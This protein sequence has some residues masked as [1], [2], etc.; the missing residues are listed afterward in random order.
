MDIGG[1]RRIQQWKNPETVPRNPL[2]AL[3]KSAKRL[4]LRVKGLGF[5][6]ELEEHNASI[7]STNKRCLFDPNSV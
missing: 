1:F 3:G 5:K 6:A 4:G 7:F 2:C